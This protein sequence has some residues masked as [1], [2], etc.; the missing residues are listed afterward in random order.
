MSCGKP[1]LC[2]RVCDN[3]YI[4]RE[5][6]NAL[7]FDNTSIEDMADKIKAMCEKSQ[8]E[9]SRWGYRSRE[10]AEALF[11]MDAFVEKYIKLIENS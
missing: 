2:S 10:M 7:M 4:V 1:I 11:S 3:P 6:E 9:L 8:E 5:G